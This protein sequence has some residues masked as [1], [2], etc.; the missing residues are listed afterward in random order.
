M[1]GDA[2]RTPGSPSS[3]RN[4]YGR[5]T[6]PSGTILP[7]CQNLSLIYPVINDLNRVDLST[8]YIRPE[9]EAKVANRVHCNATGRFLGPCQSL[10]TLL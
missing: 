9:R 6:A 5:E 4:D 2:W 3:R 7:G 10:I 8:S 1:K